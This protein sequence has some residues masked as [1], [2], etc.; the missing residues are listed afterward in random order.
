MRF[1]P[2]ALVSGTIFFAACSPD[3]TCPP[4]QG[5]HCRDF[6]ATSEQAIGPASC[7]GP[8]TLEGIDVSSW[9]GSIDW[10]AVAA[11]G[12]VF[13]VARVSDG[14]YE[15]QDFEANWSG[16][17]SVGM[18]RGVYQFFRPND[19]PI[20]QADLLLG[21]IGALEPGDLAPVIDVEDADGVGADFFRSQI[22]AWVQ[23][24]EAATG[25]QPIIYV[26]GY[27]WDDNVGGND[28]ANYPLWLPAYGPL[29]PRLPSPWAGWR[30]HQYSSTG[31]VPGISGNV[32][33]DK[34]NG[35]RDE[36]TIF[37]GGQLC[38]PHCE[39][40]EIVGGD[41]GRGD[42]AVFGSSCVDDSLGA[43]CV[44]AFCPAIGGA[45]IC[46]NDSTIA[47]CENGALTSQGDCGAYAAYCSTA[48][49]APDAG[50]CVSIFCVQSPADAPVAHDACFLEP[51]QVV[52]CDQN[53]GPTV[54]TCP[55]DQV[56]TTVDDRGAVRCAKPEPP[57]MVY[58]V[59]TVVQIERHDA[60]QIAVE[61][62]D[63]VND[64]C[65]CISATRDGRRSAWFFL[66]PLA[67]LALCVSFPRVRSRRDRSD[68]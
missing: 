59:R 42:C 44:F 23:H 48:G 5:G 46:L 16:I 10:N 27:F 40:T 28:F 33:L 20:A 68:R 12:K 56:C 32:D 3:G 30:M 37:A 6:S 36:L 35:T 22:G 51:N 29:C 60:P 19:D 25:R 45:D 8:V 61:V 43:R 14:F 4:G 54:E 11:S 67:L 58:P 52:H 13:A 49:V 39:G 64:G 7:P 24:V 31:S 57:P 18:I 38:A 50:R 9:Q 17:K 53:G 26:G 62:K 34:F 55:T 1:A 63:P 65:S 15:D 21:K 66:A 47:H 41:C 2:I